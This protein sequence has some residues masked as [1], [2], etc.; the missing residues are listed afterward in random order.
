L[1]WGDQGKQVS[2]DDSKSLDYRPQASS[3]LASFVAI[4]Y[5]TGFAP[6]GHRVIKLF[7]LADDLIPGGIASLSAIAPGRYRFLASARKPKT[8]IPQTRGFR[9]HSVNPAEA[10]DNDL[11][12]GHLSPG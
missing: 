12:P 9:P 2:D 1:G 8:P 3:R 10:I 7:A 5:D 6:C 11:D 4:A